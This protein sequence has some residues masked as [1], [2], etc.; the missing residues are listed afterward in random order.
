V[1]LAT[2]ND[3]LWTSIY[4]AAEAFR[5]AVTNDKV[6]K[7]YSWNSFQAIKFLND[8][9]GIKGLMARAVE[10]KI[11]G[12]GDNIIWRNSSVFSDWLWKS[13]TS[14]DEV[15]GHLWVYPIVYSLVAETPEEKKQA[16]DLIYN[17]VN[18]L[19]ENG[20]LLIDVTGNVTSWGVWAP[21]YL[22][23]DPNWYVDTGTNSMQMLSFLTS[24]YQMTG[25]QQF[26]D[27]INTLCKKYHY[28]INMVNTLIVHPDDINFSD[29][30]LI[31]FP[32]Y[33]LLTSKKMSFQP[34]FERSINRTWFLTKNAKLS[35]WNVIYGAFLQSLGNPFESEDFDLDSIIWSLKTNPTSYI[36]WP[37]N[38][39]IRLDVSYSNNPG[40]QRFLTLLPFDELG[41]LGWTCDPFIEIP[42]ADGY[43][44]KDTSS[45]LL[46]YWMARY[47]GFIV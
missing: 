44:E 12:I 17:I 24:V 37:V 15:V 13:D 4:I 2:D 47:H 23:D 45:W 3:G 5:Y 6:A 19:R 18:Y 46:S 22:N 29:D 8:V 14:S 11:N 25:N 16:R 33:T 31:F 34:F 35:I 41:C 36:Y 30:Q 1:N 40:E 27:S 9:T 20:Y 21:K 28:D 39:T 43:A 38:N 26:L 32:Y 42:D 7:N 10:K